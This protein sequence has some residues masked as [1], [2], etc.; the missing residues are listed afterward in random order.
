MSW[1]EA[2]W[3]WSW[4]SNPGVGTEW[5]RHYALNH[6]TLGIERNARHWDS[7]PWSDEIAGLFPKCGTPR[8]VPQ[9][10]GGTRTHD[11]G[12]NTWNIGNRTKKQL[13]SAALQ[14]LLCCLDRHD[15]NFEMVLTTNMAF[16][17]SQRRQQLQW[18][19]G[20]LILRVLLNVLV[21]NLCAKCLCCWVVVIFRSTVKA[22]WKHEEANAG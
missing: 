15:S 13:V 6:E 14:R 9:N 1:H 16:F 22:R 11:W 8:G 12:L 18:K 4:D 3:C 21:D 10:C 5:M 2:Q 17:K 7:N 19:H 20:A